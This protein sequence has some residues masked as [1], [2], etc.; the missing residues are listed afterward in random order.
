MSKAFFK[1]SAGDAKK[2][3]LEEAVGGIA[4]IGMDEAKNQIK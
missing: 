1:G 3:L 4:G 2:E